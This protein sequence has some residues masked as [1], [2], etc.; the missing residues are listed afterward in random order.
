MDTDNNAS[1]FDINN[2]RVTQKYGEGLSSK[3]L[4]I[5]ILFLKLQCLQK[6]ENMEK[7]ATVGKTRSDKFTSIIRK[8]KIFV[9]LRHIKKLI[10]HISAK[11]QLR[12]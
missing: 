4:I 11:Q 2:Y 3:K 9:F 8:H 6:Y 12:K 7:I 5:A 1:K 10:W